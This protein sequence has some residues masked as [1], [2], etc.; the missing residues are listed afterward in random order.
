MAS[1]AVLQQA[2]ADFIPATSALERELQI[3]A[4]VQECTS[5]EVLPEAYRS[6]DRDEVFVRAQ[7]AAALL[8]ETDR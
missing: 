5:R 6:M 3:L 1:R 2:F 4:A 7:R 8:S